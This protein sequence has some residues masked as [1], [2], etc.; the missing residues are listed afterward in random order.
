MVK[1]R[2]HSRWGLLLAAALLTLAGPPLAAETVSVSA[3][4]RTTTSGRTSASDG[5]D[6][7][8][9]PAGD[10][11]DVERITVIAKRK[12]LDPGSTPSHVTVITA[13]EIKASGARNVAE[14][15]DTTVGTQVQ[16]YG[17]VG[18]LA[19]VSI[20]GSSN[21]QVLVL[22]NGKRL[23]TAQGGG[24][25]F[26]SLN[27]EDI[28]RIE[29]IRGGSSAIYGENAFGGVINIVTKS[30][31]GK[32]WQGG[33]HYSYGSYAT[34]AA[35]GS[36]RGPWGPDKRGDF[37][38]SLRGLASEGGY[39]FTD[40]KRGTVQARKNS[41]LLGVDGSVRVGFDLG[42]PRVHRLAF[43]GQLHYRDKGVPGMAD[44]PTVAA[45]MTDR[46]IM[47]IFDYNCAA[48]PFLPGADLSV[49]VY[50]VFHKRHFTDPEY[51]LGE[52]DDWHDNRAVG[53]DATLSGRVV[54]D[55]LMQKY[56][57]A[58]TG[59]WD[60]LTSTGLQKSPG[61]LTDGEVARIAHSLSAR[62]ELHLWRYPGKE[63]DPGV[64]R[65]VFVPALRYDINSL[66]RDFLSWQ[67]GAMVH[68]DAGKRLV[69]KGNAGTSY[70]A[71]SF[72]DLF[73]PQTA[74]AI[75]NPKLRPEISFGWDA[76][77]LVKPFPWLTFELVYFHNLVEDLIQW[78]PGPGGQWRPSNVGQ[79]LL[80]GV[81]AEVKTIL[82]IAWLK[83]Y[84]EVGA[85]YT[86]LFATDKSDSPATYDKQLARRPFEKANAVVS[87]SRPQW[88]FV[89]WETRFV[90]FRYITAH[91]TKYFEP[92][93][94]HS[95]N[96]GV[97]VFDRVE[98]S[99]Q[100]MNLLDD[101]YI[102]VREYPIPGREISVKA[103]VKL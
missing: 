77:G 49:S 74:F 90:G 70:R 76:G 91:N 69:L 31:R 72:N 89:R 17:S 19:T 7:R 16:R 18:A 65:V 51:F 23:N 42:E 71:P 22:M 34:Q 57:A 96:A 53:G 12:H 47:G 30:G 45:N 46:R 56:R 92:Y 13:D 58:Y 38:I 5:G 101:S 29:V 54:W 78:V 88:Y 40:Q 9:R 94:V 28:E 21:E 82:T 41:G 20:R 81:E 10:A 39:L 11:G 85:N 67:L 6:T 27:P 50:G 55:W 52:I 1:G 37:Y 59:R 99:A 83:S 100:V 66:Y 103:G 73:W 98:L 97:T 60:W 86:L 79:A 36:L 87:L 4:G 3:S 25:D 33:L 75:G 62:D 63:G 61:I 93:L 95:V 48:L 43:S 35:D 8:R 24:V 32:K 2:N 102:D 68:F 80:E 44:F 64:G 26:S 84:L 15:L 14:V